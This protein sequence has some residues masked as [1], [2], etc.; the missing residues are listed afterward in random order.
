[1]KTTGQN[2]EV[3][4]FFINAPFYSL[5]NYII[6]FIKESLKSDKVI[7]FEIEPSSPEDDRNPWFFDLPYVIDETD[8]V[9]MPAHFLLLEQKEEI[10]TAITYNQETN[11]YKFLVSKKEDSAELQEEILRPCEL[12]ELTGLISENYEINSQEIVEIVSNSD[13]QF[14]HLCSKKPQFIYVNN[15]LASF[16]HLWEACKELFFELEASADEK[17]DELHAIGGLIA[18]LDEQR[19]KTPPPSVH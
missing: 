2:N 15:L 14:F 1:M 18:F 7:S 19:K 9:C 11:E 6:P 8:C 5:E 13:N 17:F 4:L 16:E 12:P 3:D 10:A